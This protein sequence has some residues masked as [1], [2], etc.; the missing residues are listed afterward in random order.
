MTDGVGGYY[1]IGRGY[2][3]TYA[4]RPVNITANSITAN[5]FTVPN[6]S[7]GTFGGNAKMTGLTVNPATKKITFTTKWDGSSNGTFDVTLTQVQ[8]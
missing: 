1:N 4:A 2:G 7:V 6:F 3:V 8:P 5:D